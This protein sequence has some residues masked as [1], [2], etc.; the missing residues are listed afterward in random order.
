MV[1]KENEY[2]IKSETIE[3]SLRQLCR[4]SCELF[5]DEYKSGRILQ[6][7]RFD[8]TPVS[9]SDKGVIVDKVDSYPDY[10]NFITPLMK[11]ILK[12]HEAKSFENALKADEKARRHLEHNITILN[13]SKPDTVYGYIWKFVGWF[14]VECN[15][16]A[17]SDEVF[18]RIYPTFEEYLHSDEIPYITFAAIWHLSM[19]AS[20]IIFNDEVRLS[21]IADS[22]IQKYLVKDTIPFVPLPIEPKYHYVLEVSGTTPKM[23]AKDPNKVRFPGTRDIEQKIER[24]LSAMRIF[25]LGDIK[26]TYLD[27]I[28]LGWTYGEQQ[29]ISSR[30]GD[31]PRFNLMYHLVDEEIPKLVEFYSNFEFLPNTGPIKSALSSFDSSFQR[32]RFEDRLVDCVT[33]FEALLLTEES[34]LQFRLALRVA[35]LLGN[36]SNEREELFNQTKKAYRIRSAIVHGADSQ[37]VVKE[38]KGTKIHN[39]VFQ[40]Q[41]TLRCALR[42]YC[43]LYSTNKEKNTIISELDDLIIKGSGNQPNGGQ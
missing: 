10:G 23:F 21:R 18:D 8:R 25:K 13:T 6:K 16:F 35:A 12:F 28:P 41:E 7:S 33:S 43:V 30:I 38:L 37:R 11:I 40:F 20:E 29:R 14:V 24:V 22:Q 31:S 3:K 26:L 17:F 5:L 15:G 32:D 39:F 19:E 2:I 36:N 1:K 42:R 34:E 27:I 9:L 4:T